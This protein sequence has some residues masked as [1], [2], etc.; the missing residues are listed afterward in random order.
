MDKRKSE[1]KKYIKNFKR[2]N[3]RNKKTKT[4][5]QSLLNLKVDKLRNFI[6]T[7]R[8][9]IKNKLVKLFVSKSFN[10]F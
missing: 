5:N 1:I 9:E 8:L 4:N 10:S 3:S 7:K 2:I 6:L